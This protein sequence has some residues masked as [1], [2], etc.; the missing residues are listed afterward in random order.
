MIN[1]I[2]LIEFNSIVK[3]IEVCDCMLKAANVTPLKCCSVCPGKYIA[4][5]AGDTGSVNAAMDAGEKAGG[6]FIVDV[7]R[8][9]KAHAQL[10]PAISGVAEVTRGE[11]VGGLEFF[12]IASAILAADEAPK[13]ASVSLI[14]VKIGYAVGGKGVVLFTG[15][16]GA[17]QR[18][19][20]AAKD[21]TSG[22]G[23]LVC[24]TLIN[25]PNEYLYQSLL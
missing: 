7:L 19:L 18:A 14:D 23:L 5:I 12:S 9:P 3:G 17:V 1:A 22:A 4:L 25:H 8:I 10:I 13:A 21:R 20:E 15:E 16:T 6:E 2:G 11:A 24:S